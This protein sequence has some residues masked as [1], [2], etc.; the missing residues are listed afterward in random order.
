MS[1]LA[2]KGLTV[3]LGGTLVLA[4]VSLAMRNGGVSSFTG[5]TFTGR[6]AAGFGAAATGAGSGAAATSLGAGAA[7]F[8]GSFFAASLLFTGDGRAFRPKGCALPITALRL[9]PPSSSAI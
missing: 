1:L 9:T 7:F 4:G 3:R 6:G 5:S 8:T 2:A